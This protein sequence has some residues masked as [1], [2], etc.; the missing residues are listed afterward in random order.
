[1]KK[2]R[3][4]ASFKNRKMIAEGIFISKLSYVIALWGGCGAGLKRSLQVLQNK[5]AQVVTRQDWNTPSKVLLQQCGWL[6]VNQMIFFH[7]VLLVFKVK[8][9]RSP[10]YMY[11]MHNNWTYHYTTR[12]A[13]NGLIRVAVRPRLELVRDSFRWRAANNFNQLPVDF[14]TC[15]EVEVFKKKIKP[16]IKENIPH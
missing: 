8:L 2:I 15:S 1:M 6:S 5:V 14:R 3:Y 4:L 7:S 16:W 12:Q 10:K 11:M 9:S 13:E